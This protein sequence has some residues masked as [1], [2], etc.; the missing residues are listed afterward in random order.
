MNKP[1]VLRQDVACSLDQLASD[2]GSIQL[3]DVER[4]I[5]ISVRQ[6]ASNR[7]RMQQLAKSANTRGQK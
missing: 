1:K 3:F 5:M 2:V 4:A 7:D 6:W